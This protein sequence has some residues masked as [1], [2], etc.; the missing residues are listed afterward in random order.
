[1]PDKKAK[2]KRAII[3]LF[4]TFSALVFAIFILLGLEKLREL[5]KTA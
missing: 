1:V 4:S 2:P 3:V 5:R